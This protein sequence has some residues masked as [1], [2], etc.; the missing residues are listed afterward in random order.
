M[1]WII[2]LPTTP[3]GDLPYADQ[4]IPSPKQ[5]AHAPVSNDDNSNNSSDTTEEKSWRFF[6]G[7]LSGCRTMETILIELSRPGI[8]GW[9][10]DPK[11]L[12]ESTKSA[13]QTLDEWYVYALEVLSC[14]IL[15][16][17]FPDSPLTTST[18]APSDV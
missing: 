9:G 4:F 7:I 3:L 8:D 13:L 11:G 15:I 16:Q 10:H 2:P 17:A 14:H 5:V 12:I 18:Q 6:L 1:Q